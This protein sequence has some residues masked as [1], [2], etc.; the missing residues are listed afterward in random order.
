MWIYTWKGWGVL[1]ITLSQTL[2]QY[3]LIKLFQSRILI[4]A[5]LT[6]FSKVLMQGKLI[7]VVY[8]LRTYWN[9]FSLGGIFKQKCVHLWNNFPC[10]STWPCSEWSVK[11]S[12]V[13]GTFSFL[14]RVS[15]KITLIVT[16]K[17]TNGG[18]G[19]VYIKNKL[20]TFNGSSPSV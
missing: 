6:R 19:F 11:G 1:V 15:Q 16:F 4:I 13:T 7:A 8:T 9:Q 17:E 2:T 14:H 20:F 3:L 5:I 12:V 18:K 10:I